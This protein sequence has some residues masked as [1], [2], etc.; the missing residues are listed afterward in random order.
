MGGGLGVNA[1]TGREVAE[2]LIHHYYSFES[3]WLERPTLDAVREGAT[4][5]RVG[6][7]GPE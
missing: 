1:E 3:A 2:K 6:F 4:R 7:D 5:R